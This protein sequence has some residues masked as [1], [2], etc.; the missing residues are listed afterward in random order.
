MASFGQSL[1]SIADQIDTCLRLEMG[2]ALPE[3]IAKP[4]QNVTQFMTD[5]MNSFSD[6]RDH[7]D[8][9]ALLLPV[10]DEWTYMRNNQ[11][12]EARQRL[13]ASIT[14]RRFAASPQA[15]EIGHIT[16]EHLFR[17]MIAHPQ[18]MAKI[19]GILSTDEILKIYIEFWSNH[20][21]TILAWVQKAAIAL[22]D[23]KDFVEEDEDE[24]HWSP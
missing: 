12:R 1:A 9:P 22:D 16:D 14:L 7:A 6:V 15:R 21:N 24:E 5:F 23:K 11:F 10:F 8:A 13:I 17:W 2:E 18:E 19:E 3:H 20:L 4:D